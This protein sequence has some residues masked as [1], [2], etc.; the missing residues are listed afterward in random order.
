M[1]IATM[2]ADMESAY[3]KYEAK[4]AEIAALVEQ[5]RILWI[6]YWQADRKKTV[7]KAWW[8]RLVMNRVRQKMARGARLAAKGEYMALG[9]MLVRGYVFY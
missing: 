9:E 4:K 3:E 8:R 6:R 1:D 7:R 2:T 5:R